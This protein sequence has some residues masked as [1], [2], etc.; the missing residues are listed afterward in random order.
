M[1][2]KS[3][4]Q[5][6]FFLL[7]TSGCSMWAKENSSQ[8]MIRGAISLKLLDQTAALMNVPALLKKNSPEILSAKFCRS[9]RQF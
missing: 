8:E 3:E 2:L 7:E 5:T 6:I 9:H 1:N 4:I